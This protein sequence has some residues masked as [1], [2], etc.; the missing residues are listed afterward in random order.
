[1]RQVQLRHVNAVCKSLQH[2]ATRC[3]NLQQLHNAPRGCAD[4]VLVLQ[5]VAGVLQCVAMI[6]IGICGYEGA[7]APRECTK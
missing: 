3:N 4:D 6:Y 2:A 1:M 5:C 7:N